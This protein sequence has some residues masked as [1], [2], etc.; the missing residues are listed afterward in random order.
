MFAASLVILDGVEV[1][2]AMLPCF[3]RHFRRLNNGWDFLMQPSCA[4]PDCEVPS[5]YVYLVQDLRSKRQVVQIQKITLVKQRNEE[6][7]G[8]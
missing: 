2:A 6:S 1:Q 3:L 5:C 4:G 8:Q 7:Q